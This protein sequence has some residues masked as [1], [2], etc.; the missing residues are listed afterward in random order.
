[1][2]LRLAKLTICPCGYSVLDD[3]IRIGQT[4]T[5]YPDTICGGYKY[6]CGGCKKVLTNVVV[7]KT[8]SILDPEEP[9][10]FLPFGLFEKT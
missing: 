6:F 4:Y 10:K 9:P 8:D 7:I 1:M 2:K 5:V 3:G